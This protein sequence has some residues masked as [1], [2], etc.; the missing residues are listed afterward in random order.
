MIVVGVD[1]FY[2]IYRIEV[3]LTIVQQLQIQN[4]YT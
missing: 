4:K 3:K 1:D 2:A